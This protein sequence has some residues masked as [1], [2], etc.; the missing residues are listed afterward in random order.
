[1]IDTFHSISI[2]GVDAIA[3]WTLS[4]PRDLTVIILGTL[5]GLFL[6]AIR[7]M[8]VDQQQIAEIAADERRLRDLMH[9]AKVGSDQQQLARFRRTRILVRGKRTQ[10]EF[11][12]LCVSV[13]VLSAITS[14]G[15]QRLD[16]FPIQPGET[17]QI[18]VRSPASTVNEI[19]HVVPQYTLTS[20]GGWVRS[21]ESDTS[22]N[23]PSGKADWSLC[24]EQT[25]GEETINVRLGNQTVQH[26]LNTRVA[27]R[28]QRIQSHAG[29][30][31]TE[32]VLRP[33]QPLGW[34]PQHVWPGIPG[35]LVVLSIT[36]AAVYWTLEIAQNFAAGS[37]S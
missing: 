28:S 2:L 6:F 1:M 30:I 24:F 37:R 5:V 29:L 14:W 9:N 32:V 18:R 10:A 31:E 22:T 21:I 17:F 34:L 13:L 23:L 33:Y 20:K 25:S 26:V 36:T 19:I 8:T 16:D 7:Q 35:W 11:V 3:G 27:S 4:F 12:S 15:Q